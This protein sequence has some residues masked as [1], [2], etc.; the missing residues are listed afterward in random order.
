VVEQAREWRDIAGLEGR[1]QVSN[2]G[3]VRS[4]PDIDARGRFMPGNILKANINDKGYAHMAC[5]GQWFRVHRLVAEAFI[6]NPNA[7]PQVNHK[8]GDKQNNHVS[9]LEWCTNAENH[10]HRY[11]VLGHVGG[12]TGKQGIKCPNSKP[13]AAR[14]VATGEHVGV[15]GSA[16]EAARVLGG[17]QSGVNQCANGKLR[18]YKGMIWTYIT[19]GQYAEAAESA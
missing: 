15:F 8:D 17:D 6:P 13:V 10:L 16:S 3:Y 5:A 1:Y 7:L 4:L 14:S 11:R 2:D 9:N 18:S 19:R 12:M